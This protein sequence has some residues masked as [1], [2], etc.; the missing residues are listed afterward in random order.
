MNQS[1]IWTGEFVN[2]VFDNVD[3]N[4][5]TL[6][7]HDTWHVMG[8]IA[9]ITLGGE[10]TEPVIPRSQAVRLTAVAGIYAKVS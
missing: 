10:Y 5:R 7:G 3:L 2:F 8:G 1:M 9:G 4:I 6:T